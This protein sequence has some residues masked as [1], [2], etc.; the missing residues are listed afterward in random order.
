MRFLQNSWSCDGR[1]YLKMSTRCTRTPLYRERRSRTSVVGNPGTIVVNTIIRWYT[2]L[3]FENWR[4]IWMGVLFKSVWRRQ[5]SEWVWPGSHYSGLLL[6][7]KDLSQRREWLTQTTWWRLES[8][9]NSSRW[10]KSVA[11]KW[12]TEYYTCRVAIV[13]G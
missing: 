11:L 6:K 10:T 13:C 9:T 7:G 4:R 8:S 3:T 2:R 5:M 1:C 12:W